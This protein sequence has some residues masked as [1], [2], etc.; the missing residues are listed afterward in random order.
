M[1][2]YLA[3]GTT[4]EGLI[5]DAELDRFE[6]GRNLAASP[7]SVVLHNE[8]FELIHYK[9]R[10]KLVY[11][12]PVLIVPPT[13]N[14]FYLLDLAPGRSVVEYLVGQGHQVFM[15]SWRNPGR[16]QGHFDF[17]TYAAA[18]LEAQDTVSEISGR[19]SVHLMAACSGGVIAAGALGHLAHQGELDR[20]A[21]LTLLV[22]ALDTDQGGT[23]R[24]LT[25]R[26]VAALAVAESARRGYLAGEALASVFAWM[27]PNEQIWNHLINNYW[28]GRELQAF[29]ILYWTQD[30]ARMAAGLHRDFVKL[31]LGNSLTR[32]G[33][34]RVL[35]TPVSLREVDVDSYVVAGAAD[36]I[37]PWGNAYRTTQLLGGDS[38]FVLS[39]GGHI[40][41]L[42][43]PP[44][45][46]SRSGYRIA[47]ANP[48]AL[49]D[50]EAR[51]SHQSGSW[52]SDYGRWLGARSGARV[53]APR[54]LGSAVHR[55]SAPAPGAYVVA[56]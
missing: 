55:P 33:A 11:E 29:D 54:R 51:A 41:A 14:K 16:A 38:R 18:A 3:L 31:A 44:G 27:R 6:L 22:C 46:G 48:P 50:W 47:P 10:T 53:P 36:H 20:V 37:V 5:D 7:G 17:D 21:S 9:P 39:T 42:I 43:N 45:P 1:Q 56:P 49:E 12:T 13:I 26:D 25:T 52:W 32:A 24:A 35:G 19:E 8:V 40:Q 4:V 28:L 34:F 15:V 30:T 23:A 2:S